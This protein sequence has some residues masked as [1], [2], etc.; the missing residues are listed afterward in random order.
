MGTYRSLSK[1]EKCDGGAAGWTAGMVPVLF[2]K[3]TG[4]E[5]DGIALEAVLCCRLKN[6][7]CKSYLLTKIFSCEWHYEKLQLPKW[8]KNSGCHC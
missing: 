4:A 7:C 5:H 1:G 3:G 6:L 2:C 8:D